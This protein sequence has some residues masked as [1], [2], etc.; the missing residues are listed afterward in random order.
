MESTEDQA[1]TRREGGSGSKY[2]YS[3]VALLLLTGLTFGLHYIDLSWASMIVALA[4]A[5]VKVAVVAL[6]FMELSK[7][8]IATRV[9]AVLAVTFVVL[10]CL[11]M[12]GDVGFR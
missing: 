12:L 1:E 3:L 2:V 11:G 7:T 6:V 9:V 4:I 10:L 5:T 8:M